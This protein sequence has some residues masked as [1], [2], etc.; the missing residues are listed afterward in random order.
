[1]FDLLGVPA[2]RGR[3]LIPADDSPASGRV[4]VVS[5]CLWTPRFGADPGLIGR[6]LTLDGKAYTVTGIMPEH[7]AFAPFWATKAEMWTPLPLDD[8]KYDRGGGSL[9]V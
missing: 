7:F 5:H 3:T 2:V 4:L 6:V 1:M 9:P 8:R